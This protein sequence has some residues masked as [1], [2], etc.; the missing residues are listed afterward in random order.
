MIKDKKLEIRPFNRNQWS[1]YSTKKSRYQ[2]SSDEEQK[3]ID[4]MRNNHED[5]SDDN[6]DNNTPGSTHGNT[7]GSTHGNTN[8]S[9]TDVL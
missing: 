7:N 5:A 3:R 8:D 1:R 6:L 9:K 2:L 4:E